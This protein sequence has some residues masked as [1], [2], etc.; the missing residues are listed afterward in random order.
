MSHDK[1]DLIY[2]ALIDFRDE[3]REEFKEIKDNAKTHAAEMHE[4]KK[5]MHEK[6]EKIDERVD[7][8]EEPRKALGL[9]K[10]W[11]LWFVAIVGAL[12]WLKDLV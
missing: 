5:D 2:D 1:T 10:V 3:T 7:K 11:A 8:L 4:H 9:I 6:M 12:R